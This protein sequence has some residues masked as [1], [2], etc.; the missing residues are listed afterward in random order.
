VGSTSI[1]SN[2]RGHFEAFPDATTTITRSWHKADTVLFEYVEGGTNTGAHG[3]QKPTGKKVG[4]IGASVLQFTPNGRVK[5]D[6]TYY[7]E[8]TMEVQAGWAEGPLAKLEV[9]PVIAVPAARSDWEVHQI[10]AND[11]GQTKLVALRKSLY[12]SVAMRSEKD[13]LAALGDDVVL[14]AYDEPKDVIGKRDAATLFNGWTKTFAEQ[15]VTVDEAWTVDGHV[16]LLGTFSGKHVGPWGPLKAT[17]KPFKSHFLDITRVS[18][19]DK[20]ERVW[21]YANNFELLKHLGYR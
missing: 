12:S 18:K 4:Y 10:S 21:T 20:V 15:S 16:V 19:D 9:R 7:D 14:A 8:L 17:N 2:Y 6:T 1:E 13:F 3:T 11:V 5:R